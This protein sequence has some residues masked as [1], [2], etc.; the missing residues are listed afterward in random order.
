MGGKAKLILQ[1]VLVGM[2]NV[3]EYERLVQKWSTLD[4]FIYNCLK[5]IHTPIT[6][7]CSRFKFDSCFGDCQLKESDKLHQSRKKV[8]ENFQNSMFFSFDKV[9]N[10]FSVEL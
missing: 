4:I 3:S 2:L 8:G 6:A 9:K 5:G 1:L 7:L 10:I